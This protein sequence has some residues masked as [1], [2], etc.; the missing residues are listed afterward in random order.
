MEPASRNGTPNHSSD[1]W[2]TDTPSPTMFSFWVSLRRSCEIAC[3]S[4]VV[5]PPLY[6]FCKLNCSPPAYRAAALATPHR[7]ARG[8]FVGVSGWGI[9]RDPGGAGSSAVLS[10]RED[11]ITELLGEDKFTQ[12]IICI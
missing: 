3:Q 12:A 1:A 9:D 2:F 11:R 5:A 8:S 10:S 7:W 6:A 4:L